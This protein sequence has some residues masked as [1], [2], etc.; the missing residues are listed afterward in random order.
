MPAA[1]MNYTELVSQVK[2]YCE[3]PN[4]AALATQIPFLILLAENK[5]AAAFKSLG[6]Q[7]VVNAALVSGAN[8]IAK[9]AYWRNSLSFRIQRPTTEKRVPILLRSYEFCREFAPVATALG[10][11]RYYSDYNYENFFIAPT[12]DDNYPFELIYF[13][14]LT[15]LSAAAQVNW[16]TD[17]APQLLI[18]ACM[19]EAQTWLKNFDKVAVWQGLYTTALG[20]LGAEDNARLADRNTVV[21]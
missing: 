16:F 6:V 19:V 15:P 11:P 9:P 1:S 20:E 18:Y 14:R 10:E 2:A 8:T 13:P 21:R 5:L 12:P 17:N 4:D 3:R 7:Q